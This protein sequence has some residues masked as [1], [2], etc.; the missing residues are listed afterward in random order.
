MSLADQPAFPRP[1]SYTDGRNNQHCRLSQA[2]MTLRQHYAGLAMQG[3][4]AD[5]TL[6]A[7]CEDFAREAVEF[8]DALIAELEKPQP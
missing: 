3:M 1:F 7:S 8:A 6:S 5:H 2:G 4:L